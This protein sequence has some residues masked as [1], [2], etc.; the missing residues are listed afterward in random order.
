MNLLVGDVVLRQLERKDL[1]ALCQF[2]NDSEVA[3]LLGGYS[4]GYSEEGLVDW[5]DFHRR[6]DDEVLWAIA[7][8]ESDQCLGHVGLYQIDHRVRSAE[9][10][11]LLGDKSRWGKGTGTRITVAVLDYAF[12]WLNLNRIE[13]SVLDINPRA[14]H[15]YEK[16]GF[17]V[18]GIRRQAQFKNGAYVDVKLMSLL[19][20]ETSRGG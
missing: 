11:I 7:D 12:D 8:Q 6:R 1:S 14:V 4:R 19:R 18:E 13:L 10:A 20:G 3:A 17:S 16:L 2:K 5:L 9:F 15:L